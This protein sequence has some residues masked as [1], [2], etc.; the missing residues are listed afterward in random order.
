MMHW[1]IVMLRDIYLQ[2]AEEVSHLTR[3]LW[4]QTYFKL[5]LSYLNESKCLNSSASKH[6]ACPLANDVHKSSVHKGEGE[7]F[8]MTD[9]T[10]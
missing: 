8:W 7:S 6:I 1:S 3:I 9:D 5:L 4:E 10:V 2:L